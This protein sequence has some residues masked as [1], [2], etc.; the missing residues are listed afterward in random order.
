M[1]KSKRINY[2]EW[3][4]ESNYCIIRRLIEKNKIE[5]I[6]GRVQEKMDKYEFEDGNNPYVTNKKRESYSLYS[7]Q[8]EHYRQAGAPEEYIKEVELKY[9]EIYNEI[10]MLFEDEFKSLFYLLRIPYWRIIGVTLMRIYEGSPEQEIHHDAPDGM[11]RIFITIPLSRTSKEMGPT[12]FYDEKE[13][14]EYRGVKQS[15]KIPELPKGSFEI[16]IPEKSSGYGNIGFLK[17]MKE[18]WKEKFNKGRVQYELEKGD[19]TIHRDITYHNGGENKTKKTREF[20]F[21]V[22]DYTDKLR[23]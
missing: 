1:E 8:L 9:E 11:K 13:I 17:D 18:P 10:I 22:C 5:E 7:N 6:K 20:L 4:E 16:K 14:K 21:I 3:M 23:R 19:V 12:I 2:K 15:K